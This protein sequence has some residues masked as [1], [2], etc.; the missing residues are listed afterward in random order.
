[1]YQTKRMAGYLFASLAVIQLAA[2]FLYSQTTAHV[3]LKWLVYLVYWIRNTATAAVVTVT[4]A[5]TLLL[6]LA[7]QKKVLLF[8]I[9]PVLSRALY[10][11]PDHY[12]YYMADGLNSLEAIAM[13]TIVT[14]LECTAI[15]GAVCLLYLIAKRI[16][17]H[18][19]EE[20]KGEDAS[21]FSLENPF[22]KS[23]FSICFAHFCLQILVEIINTVSYLIENA[24]TYTF[25]EIFTILIS[26][27]LHLA[28]FLLMQVAAIA[29]T[30]Y[31]KKHYAEPSDAAQVTK[32]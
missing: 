31:A 24:G 9:L 13:A 12:L 19:G 16:Y 6:S 8:P 32:E 22:V 23:V 25:E 11:L 14:L 28:T 18:S 7:G 3:E 10:F 21:F 29:Y 1:M 26:F 20:E 4:A 15:Y 17:A 5:A 30:R 2:F 27:I